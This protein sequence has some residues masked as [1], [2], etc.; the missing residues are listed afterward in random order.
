MSLRRDLT[1]HLKLLTLKNPDKPHIICLN[2]D[3]VTM[4]DAQYLVQALGSPRGDQPPIDATV[5]IVKGDVRKA[6]AIASL[7][8]GEFEDVTDKEEVKDA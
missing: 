1:R 5:I 7:V 2:S 6:V 3:S 4:D 8:D